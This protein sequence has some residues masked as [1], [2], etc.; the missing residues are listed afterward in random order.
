MSAIRTPVK[1]KSAKP[2]SVKPDQDIAPGA[3]RPRGNPPRL[4][5]I[6]VKTGVVD[7]D[8]IDGLLKNQASTGGGD[9][10]PC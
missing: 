10:G 5:E 4:G 7:E 8:T 2:T 6:L 9:W 3:R 1:P